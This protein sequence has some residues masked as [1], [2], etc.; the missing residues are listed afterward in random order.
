[1]SRKDFDIDI[2]QTNLSQN[3][4][5]KQELPIEDKQDYLR[6]EGVFAEAAYIQ[7][8]CSSDDSE[9]YDSIDIFEDESFCNP[10]PWIIGFALAS[11]AVVSAGI[12]GYMIGKKKKR[13]FF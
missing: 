9:D 8:D 5:A 1:M 11:V 3:E 12:I 6:D 10:N 2:E 13:R 7:D 4:Q